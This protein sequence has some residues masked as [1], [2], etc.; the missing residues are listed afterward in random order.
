VNFFQPSM[1]LLSKTRTGAKVSRRY[2]AAQTPYQR[3]LAAGVLAEE[4]RER[5]ERYYAALDPVRLLRQVEL[6]QDARWRHALVIAPAAAPTSA[7][8]A[9]RVREVL[10]KD[11]AAQRA[12]ELGLLARRSSA[13]P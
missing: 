6:L 13:T 7:A 2:D 8:P 4:V 9:A 5:L 3:L 10:S 12:R 11:T 1:K